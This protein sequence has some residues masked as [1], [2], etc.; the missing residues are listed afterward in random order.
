MLDSGTTDDQAWGNFHVIY[1]LKL[2]E[3]PHMIDQKPSVRIVPSAVEATVITWTTF[4]D[5]RNALAVTAQVN[6]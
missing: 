4:K 2:C 6:Y 3:S 5:Y 1:D